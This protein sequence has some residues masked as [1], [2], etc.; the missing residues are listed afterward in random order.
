VVDGVFRQELEA[1]TSNR[2][3]RVPHDDLDLKLKLDRW[4]IKLCDGGIRCRPDA[5]RTGTTSWSTGGIPLTN[6]P[7]PPTFPHCDLL[8]SAVEDITVT[9]ETPEF[10][11]IKMDAEINSYQDDFGGDHH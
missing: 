11:E 1:W 2:D 10:V 5:R 4:P 8:R 9:W 3:T 6:R 7:D